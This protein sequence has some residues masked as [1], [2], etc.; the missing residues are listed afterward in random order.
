MA[1]TEDTWTEE[2]SG[3]Y[4]ELAAVAVPAREEQ[5][6]TLLALLPFDRQEPFRVVEAGCGEGALSAALLGCFA[7][8]SAIALDGSASMREHAAARLRRF[9][10]RGQVDTFELASTEWLVHLEQ[11][12]CLLSSLCLHHLSG[13]Q[14]QRLFA[15][16]HD[17]LT[18]RGALLIADLVE[19][20]RP[21]AR[22]LFAETWD[23]AAEAR[24]IERTGS[25]TLFETFKESKWN[26]F[27]FPDYPFDQPSPLVDQLTWLKS[28][29]FV[30][31]DCFW[32]QAGHAIYGG[33]KGPQGE[34]A[35][36][37]SFREAL[38][39]VREELDA[40]IEIGSSDEGP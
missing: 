4:R 40:T 2:A 5:L 20:G 7:H 12:D 21:E 13:V 33:Y 28:A 9:G 34:H 36:A 22:A 19:P 32:L 27:R 38:R 29:G 39:R 11:A 25:A 18:E 1:E 23:S 17:R 15:G 16:A 3:L 10:G 35:Q 8:A 30:A 6:A 37:L 26:N 31:V 14:K 24:S